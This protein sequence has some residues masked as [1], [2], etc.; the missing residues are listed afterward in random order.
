MSNIL[1]VAPTRSRRRIITIL[2][3]AGYLVA[4]A[5]SGQNALLKARAGSLELIL[6]SIVMP[7]LNGLEVAARLRRHLKKRLPPIIL[8]GYITPVGIDEEPLSSLVDGYM[9]LNV[10]S[11]DLLA[12][13]RSHVALN[14]RQAN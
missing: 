8:L 10:S 6:M 7:D 11:V 3:Q 12:T 5:D 4:E 14:N 2:R 13:V 9:D 1:V